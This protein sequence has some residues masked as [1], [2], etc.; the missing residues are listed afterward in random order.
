MGVKRHKQALQERGITARG[1]LKHILIILYYLI[2]FTLGR[3]TFTSQSGES[4]VL[5]YLIFWLLEN[6]TPDL[7]YS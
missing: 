2:F 4:I 6:A 7:C 5:T 1:G 3:D